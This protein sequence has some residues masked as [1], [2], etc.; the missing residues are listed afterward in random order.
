M[1]FQLLE[2]FGENK[3]NEAPTLYKIIALV[4][5]ECRD[6]CVLH[7]LLNNLLGIF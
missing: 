4:V 6:D 2:L 1:L 5:V 3:V 7:F